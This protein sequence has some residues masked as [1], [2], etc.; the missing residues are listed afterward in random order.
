M[1]N[2]PSESP[3][4]P[5]SAIHRTALEL[6]LAR[7]RF[8]ESSSELKSSNAALAVPGSKSQSRAANNLERKGTGRKQLCAAFF[9]SY[10]LFPTSLAT[11]SGVQHYYYRMKVT[12]RHPRFIEAKVRTHKRDRKRPVNLGQAFRLKSLQPDVSPSLTSLELTV[13]LGLLLWPPPSSYLLS[14]TSSTTPDSTKVRLQRL[15]LGLTPLPST[16]YFP[17]LLHLQLLLRVVLHRIRS[18]KTPK[19]AR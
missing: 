16:I 12:T 15:T 13:S 6:R 8:F 18:I 11:E 19:N 9:S 4:V 5:S 14:L 3:K 7:L 10:G 2:L 17:T 1:Q